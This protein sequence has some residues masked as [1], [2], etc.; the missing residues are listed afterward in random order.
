[1]DMLVNLS[2]LPEAAC[3]KG[4]SIVR[5]LPP[6]RARVLAFV[7][8]NFGENWESECGT[9]LAQLPCRCLAAVKDGEI[10]GF[11]CYDTTAPGFFGPLG[12]KASCR[13]K[14]LG[15]ALLISALQAMRETG[16]GYAVIGWCD[17]KEAF[18]RR[19]VGAWPI[20]NSAPQ[21]SVYRDLFRFQREKDG[22][23]KE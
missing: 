9:A 22:S 20:P 21:N 6:D 7:R 10:V 8:E 12:V 23:A 15:R 5:V 16:Y 19:A 14:G 18:Y 1:M 17:E 11:A 4:Y 2:L 3:P 13:E